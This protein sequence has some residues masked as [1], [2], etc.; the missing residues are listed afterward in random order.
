VGGIYPL[1][2]LAYG[3][4]GLAGPTLG[5]WLYDST[6]SYIPAIMLSCGIVG[7]GLFGSAALLRKA[8]PSAL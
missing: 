8:R 4:A 1:I 3:A 7:V 6:S 2:F 5:G